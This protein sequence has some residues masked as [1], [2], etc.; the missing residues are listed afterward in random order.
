[1]SAR[2]SH[3]AKAARRKARESATGGTAP[4]RQITPARK[5]AIAE[6]VHQAVSLVFGNDGIGQCG[7]YAISGS[8]VLSR[9]T[10][11]EWIL[12][13]GEARFGTG[14]EAG[15]AEGEICY[16]FVPSATSPARTLDGK[17]AT[18][19]GLENGELHAWCV[20]P[21]NDRAAEIVDFSARHVP[22]LAERAGLGWARE[23]LPYLWGTPEDL[24]RDR[25]MHMPDLRTTE[26]VMRHFSDHQEPYKDV[27]TLALWK[28][29]IFSD[30]RAELMIHDERLLWIM[31]EG[32]TVV[33]SSDDG[34]VAVRSQRPV[35]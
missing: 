2:N 30:Q 26:T 20:R 13:A 24:W 17:Q 5:D 23:P 4:R 34:I 3:A 9:I 1:V 12:Q 10:G 8:V 16:S 35:L 22:L 19:G 29:G 28:L 33:G 25:F 21:E 18:V 32:F 31:R 15:S 11:Q 27:V 7:A 14:N 6:A